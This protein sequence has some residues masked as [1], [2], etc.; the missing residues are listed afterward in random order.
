MGKAAI[1]LA[2]ASLVLAGCDCDCDCGEPRR[3]N[4]Y[5]L[6]CGSYDVAIEIA[7]ADTLKTAINGEKITMNR[8]ISANGAKYQGKGAAISAGLRNKGG[9][10][11]LEI[12]GRAASCKSLKK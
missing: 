10:W 8:A 1:M 6:K 9:D 7:D 2:A 12:G 3:P 5:S 4:K 11:S